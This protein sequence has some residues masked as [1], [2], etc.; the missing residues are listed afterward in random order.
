MNSQQAD[1]GCI[2]KVDIGGLEPDHAAEMRFTRHAEVRRLIPKDQP[3]RVA[4]VIFSDGASTQWHHHHGLQLLWFV[5]GEGEV[6]TR[7]GESLTC[8]PGD[9]VCIE[10]NVSH[11]HGAAPGYTAVHLAITIG[12]TVWEDDDI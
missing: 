8:S 12:T 3:A 1:V 11:R 5:D 2:A 7:A 4:H 10:P 9:L 6:S